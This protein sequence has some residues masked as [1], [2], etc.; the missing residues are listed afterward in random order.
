MGSPPV[1]PEPIRALRY[2]VALTEMRQIQLIRLRGEGAFDLLDAV[3]P[4]PLFLRDGQAMHGILL[5]EGA[6]P[7]ADLYIALDDLDYLL[8]AEGP[9][10]QSWLRAHHPAGAPEVEIL[11]ER[12]QLSMLS[13]NGPYAW[14]LMSRLVSPDILGMP[15]LSFFA[16]RDWDG[17]CLRAGKTGEYGYDLVVPQVRMPALRERV[18]ALG[19]D[20]EP[21]E[22]GLADL[23]LC[24][25]ENGFFSI[26][27]PGIAALTPLELQL[28]WRVDYRR[29]FPGA[30]ALALARS[31]APPRIT[32]A[33]GPPGGAP[34]PDH[35]EVE[36]GGR[37]IGRALQSRHSPLLDRPI[38]QLLLERALAHPGLALR[39]AGADWRTVSAPL[40]H[41]RS[42]FIDT[43]RHS[44]ATR[45]LDS[46]PPV[47][48]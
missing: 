45:A 26:R 17:I 10:L 19:A 36:H 18:L 31:A 5:D 6:H 11:D 37:R 34:L 28:Q 13:L 20:M 35:T 1:L 22:A 48:P 2:G 15:Y 46:F 29:S 40:L 23:D 38:A 21:A 27:T 39:C 7:L 8:V 14:E 12:T 44:W 43:Q 4:R 25:M 16:L 3:S 30:E 24:A 33:L 47:A 32:W 41:N 42:L 9:P